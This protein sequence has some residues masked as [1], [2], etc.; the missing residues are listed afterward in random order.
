MFADVF[1]PGLPVRAA[2]AVDQ[3][4]RHELAL[5]SLHQGER[6]IPF[7]ER[8]ETT[9]KQDNRERMPDESQFARKEISEGDQL[10][11]MLN[12]RVGGLFPGQSY[13]RAKTPLRTR[14]FMSGLHDTR[15]GA[16]DDHPSSRR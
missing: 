11:I 3:H 16:R 15:P 2:R 8:A 9:R 14:P 5:S 6:F 10:F 4:Q 12:D 13:V 1:V 7:I